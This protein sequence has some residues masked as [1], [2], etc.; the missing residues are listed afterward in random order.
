MYG[1]NGMDIALNEP[2]KC[3]IKIRK[4]NKIILFGCYYNIIHLVNELMS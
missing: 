3:R 2:A 1:S 4:L